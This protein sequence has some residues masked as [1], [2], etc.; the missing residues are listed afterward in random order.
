MMGVWDVA[1]HMWQQNVMGVVNDHYV[2]AMLVMTIMTIYVRW[3]GK[4]V[5]RV[6]V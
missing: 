4:V 2:V 6:V 1:R 3:K 5:G